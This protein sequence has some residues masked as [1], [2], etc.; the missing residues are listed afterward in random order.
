MA[1]LS[2]PGCRA[3]GNPRAFLGLDLGGT[4]AKAG[5][6]DAGGRLLGQ[7]RAACTPTTTP[8]GYSE[9]PI[10]TV[11]EAARQA[12]RQALAEA[13]TPVAALALCTQGET[14]VSLDARDHPLHP[15]ILWY[16]ARAQAQAAA[17]RERLAG[18]PGAAGLAVDGICTAPKIMWLRER[19]PAVMARA[20]RYLLLPEYFAYRLTGE[21]VTDPDAA[22][23][24]GLYVYDTPEWHD[25]A[26]PAAEIPRAALARIQPAGTPV[27]RLLPSVAEQWGLDREALLVT[28][29]NDQY[30]GALGAG[31]CRPG[32]ASEMSGTCLA[33]VTLVQRLPDPLPTGLL[34]GRFPLPEYQF[35]LAYAKTAGL[36][37]EWFQ[38][39]F[40]PGLTLADLEALAA[41]SPPG[42]RGVVALPHF[43]GQVVPPDP[44]A[45]GLLYGL[46]LGHGL[47][48]LYRAPLEALAF[49]LREMLERLARAGLS[50]AVLR[51]LGGGAR[52]D[53][54]L[55][56]KADITSR[57]VERPA[58]PEAATAGAGLLAATGAGEFPS[59]REAAE[60]WYHRDRTWDPRPQETAAYDEAYH[61]WQAVRD[62]EAESRHNEGGT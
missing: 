31:N 40:A 38:R 11:Y 45:R 20:R 19:F 44:R 7:G 21:P 1:R 25:A 12:T 18:A 46:G 30:A 2:W 58:V 60:A 35:A 4:G 43:D 48:D 22:A 8:D 24:T 47:G 52:S 26:L 6:F 27:G 39:V 54:W 3:V 29:C 32:L 36:V 5:V 57:P 34:T 16:D 50:V 41:T 55:Q 17:L 37:L 61:A 56:M 9:I 13:G 59:L 62:R 23:S 49:T 33:V 14:F 51:C 28:G 15:A 53:L 10:E 42:S